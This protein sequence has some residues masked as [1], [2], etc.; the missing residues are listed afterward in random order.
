MVPGFDYNLLEWRGGND[1]EESDVNSEPE[2]S[3]ME[4][5]LRELT[6]RLNRLE[7][8]AREESVALKN[9]KRLVRYLD[10]LTKSLEDELEVE[11][12]GPP[13]LEGSS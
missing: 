13:S 6:E 8:G 7:L 2:D 1:V 9:Q 4:R 11:L 5:Q 12:P 3:E 10:V